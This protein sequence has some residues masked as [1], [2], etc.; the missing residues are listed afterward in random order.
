[1]DPVKFSHLVVNMDWEN[2]TTQ[3]TYLDAAGQEGWEL[4]TVSRGK[5]YFK[6]PINES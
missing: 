2:I 3:E 4:I 6:R 5:A 1:M